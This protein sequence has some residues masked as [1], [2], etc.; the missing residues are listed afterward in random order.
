MPV[1]ARRLYLGGNHRRAKI[2]LTAPVAQRSTEAAKASRK[3][4]ADHYPG[5][6]LTSQLATICATHVQP[7]NDMPAFAV[8][9]HAHPLQRWAFELIG[10]SRRHGLA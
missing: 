9:T 10:V 2:A 1:S 6:N 3:R 8:S 4:T 7:A 5:F